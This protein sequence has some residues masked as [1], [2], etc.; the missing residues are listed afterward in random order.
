MS[1]KLYINLSVKMEQGRITDTNKNKRHLW[2]I[3]HCDTSVHGDDV[4]KL[5]RVIQQTMS[6]RRSP[7]GGGER[8]SVTMTSCNRYQQLYLD[9]VA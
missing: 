8:G 3:N 1:E 5:I 7:G 2:E 4:S 9:L 6:G